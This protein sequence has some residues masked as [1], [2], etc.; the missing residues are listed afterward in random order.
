MKSLQ[1]IWNCLQ[2]GGPGSGR[3][4]GT[5]SARPMTKLLKANRIPRLNKSDQAK[6]I[7]N[8]FKKRMT[9]GGPG[10]GRKSGGEF[11][12]VIAQHLRSLRTQRRSGQLKFSNRMLGHGTASSMIHLTTA[13]RISKSDAISGINKV[14]KQF[15]LSHRKESM[16]EGGPGSGRR[17]ANVAAARKLGLRSL[18]QKETPEEFSK[19][20][21]K[22]FP[23]SS[24]RSRC[25][26]K[27]RREFAK[28]YVK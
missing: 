18:N 8:M 15:A 19:R 20:M 28:K 9:E 7:H 26:V 5:Q 14:A 27:D 17:A 10:S 24:P 6:I 22:L 25:W 11:R 12:S 13:P 2:E 23:S 3:K 4:K 21:N 1:E 16:F